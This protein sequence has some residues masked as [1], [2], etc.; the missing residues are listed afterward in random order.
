[1]SVLLLAEQFQLPGIPASVALAAVALIGYLV[2]K[3]SQAKQSAATPRRDDLDRALADAR[4]LEQFTDE[5]LT[6][7]REALASCRQIRA[8]RPSRL[9]ATATGRVPQGTEPIAAG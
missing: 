3:Q 9:T 1:M 4:Q 8:H 5:M 7:T 6:A 2:G